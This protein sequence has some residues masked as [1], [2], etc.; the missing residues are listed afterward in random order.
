MTASSFYCRAF[1]VLALVL[2]ATLLPKYAQA[3][4]GHAGD[5]HFDVSCNGTVERSVDGDL[6]PGN[7]IEITTGN[8]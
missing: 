1:S 4:F 3:T 5:C 8:W 6:A 7:H 2:M